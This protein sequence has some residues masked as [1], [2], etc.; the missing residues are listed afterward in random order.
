MHILSLFSLLLAAQPIASQQISEIWETSWDQSKLLTSLPQSKPINFATPGPIGDADIVINDTTLYQSI[1]GFGASLTDSSAFILTDLKFKNPDNYRKILTYMFDSADGGNVAGLNYIRVPIGAS[2]FSPQGP[3][4]FD[5]VANDT[6]FRYFDINRAPAEVF[7]VLQDIKAVNED[8]KVHI[9]PWSPPAWMKDSG[10]MNGGSLLTQFVPFYATYLLKA[11]EGF[12][13][14]GI[15]IYAVGIQNE[16]E[17]SNPT[18]PTATMTPAVEAQIG[19][20]LRSLLDSNGLSNVRII[21]Y[22]HNWS[23]AG[24]FPIELME[25]DASAFAGVAF[26]CYE[27]SDTDQMTP[28]DAYPSKEIYFTECTGTYGSDWWSDIKWYMDNLFIGSL[29]YYS[30][31][32]LMWNLALNASGDPMYPDTNS[33]SGPGCRPLVT[34]NPNG[35]YN[36][37]QEF[38]AM[39]QASKAIYPKDIGGPYGQR[40]G[41][42]VGGSL[43]WALRVGAYVTERVNKS[44]WL[45]YSL[46]VMNW[47]DNASTTFDPVPVTTTIEFRG[48]QANYTFPVGV[49][50]FSWYAPA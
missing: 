18:Y 20:A 28:Y 50:T 8:I 30:K 7:A 48:V 41:V 12:R 31:S 14:K 46:V 45:R 39:A 25:D 27:G 44:D 36:F 2:D 24:G 16:P 29:E 15:P 17:N 43:S 49:T 47:Y 38:Y 6:S 34:I 35:T 3:Y 40:I 21:G 13:S 22:E 5:D 42:S 4:S 19:A 10:T 26:H 1:S 37:N 33:C 32:A 23:D 11:V 9:V